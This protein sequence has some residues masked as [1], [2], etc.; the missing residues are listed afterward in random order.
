MIIKK[1]LSSSKRESPLTH[2]LCTQ[3]YQPLTQQTPRYIATFSG[4][5]VNGIQEAVAA[6]YF[7]EETS[8]VCNPCCIGRHKTARIFPEYN[9]ILDSTMAPPLTN[10][11]EY[12]YDSVPVYRLV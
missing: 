1:V 3:C 5:G 10:D 11:I 9:S 12:L 7:E 4:G 8:H 6:Q 2:G